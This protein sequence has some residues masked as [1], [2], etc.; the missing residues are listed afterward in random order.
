MSKTSIELVR[1]FHETFGHPISAIP[2]IPPDS[3][4]KFR[5]HFLAEECEEGEQACRDGD[6]E[7]LADS[8]CDLQYVLDGFF[9]EAGL[10]SKK[11]ELLAEV[12]RSN[13]SKSCST[14]EEAAETVSRLKTNY[15][16]V[17]FYY[18]QVKGR[19][20]VYRLSDNKVMKSYLYSKPDLKPIL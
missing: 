10:A 9:L 8:L 7:E 18:E 3:R 13:M 15:A 16:N 4:T 1:E 19:F 14:E 20:I 6:L 17:D 12:H 5:W 11:D 2:C